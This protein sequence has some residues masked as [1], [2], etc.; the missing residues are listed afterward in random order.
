MKKVSKGLKWFHKTGTA[1]RDISSHLV[2]FRLCIVHFKI[3]SLTIKILLKNLKYSCTQIEMV[4]DSG[5]RFHNV[6][7]AY[8]FNVV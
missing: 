7:K 5:K 8:Q 2:G 1:L 6:S 3:H 4:E